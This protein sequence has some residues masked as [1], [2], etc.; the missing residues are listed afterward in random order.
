MFA[1]CLTSFIFRK[2]VVLDSQA[3]R[4]ARDARTVMDKD[5]HGLKE[6]DDDDK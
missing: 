2:K 1:A 3:W 6:E 4:G 5:K